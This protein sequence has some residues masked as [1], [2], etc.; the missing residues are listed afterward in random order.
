MS[1]GQKVIQFTQNLRIPELELPP[2]FEWLFPYGQP[3]T[4]RC[5][6]EFY[7]KYYSDQRG[8]HFVFGIN[9]GRFGAGQTGVP[10]TDPLRLETECGIQNS[11]PKKAE[12]SADF[13]W[14]FIR[15]FGG[16]DVFTQSFYITSL[17]PLGFIRNGL[18]I[19]Y[20]DDKNLIKNVDAFITWNIRTQ[21]EFG[22]LGKTAICFGEGQNFAFFSKLN[23]RERFF[24]NIIP[25]PHP[26]WVMQYRRKKVDEFVERYVSTLH[27][28]L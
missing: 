22:M 24:E 25:L 18:N 28:V 8:R 7:Q 19:N 11:F 20:Y 4:M 23:Q 10:F 2:G 12:L 27:S 9:P 15:A 21:L 5:L 16:A 3:E 26:R 17:S 13:V 1:F 14:R 6:S